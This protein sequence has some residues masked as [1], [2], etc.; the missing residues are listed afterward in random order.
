MT[1]AARTTGVEQADGTIG[2]EPTIDP[3]HVASAVVYM[4]RLPLDANV[5]SLTV[6]ATVIPFIGRGWA[7]LTTCLHEPNA[8]RGSRWSSNPCRRAAK[9]AASGV[10]AAGGWYRMDMRASGAASSAED[11]P[12]QWR[13]PAG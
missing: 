9:Q 8:D 12:G 2:R 7:I 10:P 13:H 1:I 6:M 4:A 3:V 11:Q 5:Q